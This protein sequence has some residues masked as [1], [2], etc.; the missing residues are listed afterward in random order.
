V[1]VHRNTVQ[2]TGHFVTLVL[3]ISRVYYNNNIVKIGL[4]MIHPI[5]N[6]TSV[7]KHIL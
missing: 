2:L 4:I 1:C 6:V 5:S 7:P 3:I